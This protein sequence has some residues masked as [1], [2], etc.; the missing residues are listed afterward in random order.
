M[1]DADSILGGVTAGVF[2][3]ASLYALVWCVRK[4]TSSMQMKPSRSMEKLNVSDD[5]VMV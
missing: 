1:V 4:R 2:A 5:P 3:F